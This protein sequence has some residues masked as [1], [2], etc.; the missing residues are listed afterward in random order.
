MPGT[1]DEL[2]AHLEFRA[3]HEARFVEVIGSQAKEEAFDEADE[4]RAID[5]DRGLL[6]LGKHEA[7]R[8]LGGARRHREVGV[9][10]R[11]TGRLYRALGARPFVLADRVEVD[12]SAA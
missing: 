3:S 7:R 2:A 8:A 4:I 9:R 1:R 11:V 5:L 12:E 10:A 6:V